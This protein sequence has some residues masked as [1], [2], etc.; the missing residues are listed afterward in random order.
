MFCPDSYIHWANWTI[1]LLGNFILLL[2]NS[3]PAKV[4]TEE[5]LFLFVAIT[6]FS[7]S[8]QFLF[9]LILVVV[10]RM[11][12]RC[13]LPF[14]CITSVISRPF[15]YPLVK[16]CLEICPSLKIILSSFS[17]YYLQAAFTSWPKILIPSLSFL[18][19][20]Q[21]IFIFTGIWDPN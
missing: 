1:D 10:T 4:V 9:L 11:N 17:L 21:G 20:L 3:N 13:E 5:I 14:Y 2:F 16:S 6:S 18:L 15:P 19:W 8:F 7:L 12:L